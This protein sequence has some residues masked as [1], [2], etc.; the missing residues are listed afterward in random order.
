MS[1]GRPR[2]YVGLALAL[3]TC[4]FVGF[5]ASP[6]F[7]AAHRDETP[8]P[9]SITDPATAGPSVSS[10]VGGA[11]VH[12]VIGLAVVLALIFALY[13]LL[14]RTSRKNGAVIADDGV[15]S[16]V[17]STPLGPSR[18]LHLVHVGSDL[19]LVGASEQSITP[20]RTYTQEEVRRL[21]LDPTSL[22]QAPSSSAGS[23]TSSLLELLRRMTAR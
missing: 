8:L 1:S 9:K 10:G 2:P 20:I 15:I 17:S 3:L 13:K 22:A 18:S 5:Q 16:V 7:A 19:V 21:G 14:T 6:V 11:A 23:P 4:A 12:M